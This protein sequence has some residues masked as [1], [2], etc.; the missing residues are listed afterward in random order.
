MPQNTRRLDISGTF[1]RKI[2]STGPLKSLSSMYS[3]DTADRERKR[4][5]EE[6]TPPTKFQT[7][8]ND[9]KIKVHVMSIDKP[10]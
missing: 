9:N 6:P 4:C 1:Q 8:E 2:K 5:L 10:S 3:L 7:P